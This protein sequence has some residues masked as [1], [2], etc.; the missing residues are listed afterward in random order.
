[1]IRVMFKAILHHLECKRHL[2]RYQLDVAARVIIAHSH[3][4]IGRLLFFG[5]GCAA[6]DATS[7]SAHC[8]LMV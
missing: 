5:C 8:L 7:Q 6:E 1:M 2:R 4:G 3:D